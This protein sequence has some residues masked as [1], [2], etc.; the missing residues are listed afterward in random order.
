MQEHYGSKI[1]ISA[2]DWNLMENPPP[3]RGGRQGGPRRRS[4]STTR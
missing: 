1:Y 2:A 3:A 4:P